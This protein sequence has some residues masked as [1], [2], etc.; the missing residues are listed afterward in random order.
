[1]PPLQ[2]HWPVDGHVH[3]HSRNRVE[4]TLDAAAVHFRVQGGRTEGLLGALLLTQTSGE[5]VF[6]SLQAGHPVGAWTVAPA[7]DEPE[8][9]IARR[10][11]VAVAIV[12][13]RQVRAADGLEVLALGT[14]QTYPDGLP[15]ME[16]VQRVHESGAL[17][18]LPWGFGKW[19][20]ERGRRV[21][22]VLDTLGPGRVF[23]G[24][25]GN[26]LAVLGLPGLIRTGQRE[27]FRVLPGTDPFPLSGTPG[28]V[29]A[30]GFCSAI[31]PP[32]TAP[33]RALREW[34]IAQSSSPPAYGN[35][36]GPLR[37]VLDQVGLRLHKKS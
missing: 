13:G 23:L 28:R 17:T 9:L 14:C 8:S 19:V 35:A 29:G 5:R 33:W 6:E 3:F 21:E 2:L 34:L 26:R 10:G 4:P 31:E 32:A 16:A 36:V 24:D 20:G 25:N 12:C 22:Q 7:S 15:F 37:F 30:F 11:P 18:V 1:M 27:G